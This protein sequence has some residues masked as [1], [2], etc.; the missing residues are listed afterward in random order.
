MNSHKFN[1]FHPMLGVVFRG[2]VECIP[3]SNC[4][5]DGK[6]ATPI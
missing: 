6:A 1:V 5:Y 4:R 2:Q 3:H